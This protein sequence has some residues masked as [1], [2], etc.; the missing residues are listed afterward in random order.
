MAK[1]SL[2]GFG[3]PDEGNEF[4]YLCVTGRG[5]HFSNDAG[6]FSAHWYDLRHALER[7]SD[8]ER[9]YLTFIKQIKRGL[10]LIFTGKMRI[11]R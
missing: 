2:F 9:R 10:R 7:Y 1:H 11:G 4:P 6:T 8:G 3:I 5:L